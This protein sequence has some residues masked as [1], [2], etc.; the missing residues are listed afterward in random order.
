MDT[1]RVFAI[2]MIQKKSP[3]SADKN[4]THHR[5]LA[6]GMNHKEA[7]YL[8]LTINALF[9]M[10]V[11][12]FQWIGLYWLMAFNVVAG[13][14]LLL[15]PSYLLSLKKTIKADDPYQKIIFFGD[16]IFINNKEKT[17]QA[18]THQPLFG[19]SLKEKLQRISFW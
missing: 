9:T 17:V 3:F 11:I 13:G 15:L 19:K 4:H 8:I 14:C 5:L 6:L 16:N 10:T 7:T 12:S 2:R 1:L 18:R